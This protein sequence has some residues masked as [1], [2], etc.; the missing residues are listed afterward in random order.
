MVFNLHPVLTEPAE[1]SRV[2][3]AIFLMEW[4]KTAEILV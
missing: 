2:E 1:I 3:T 4:R